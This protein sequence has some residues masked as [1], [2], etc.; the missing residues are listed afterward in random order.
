MVNPFEKKYEN[1]KSWR[2]VAKLRLWS[3]SQCF[4]LFQ[5]KKNVFFDFALVIFIK[6]EKKINGNKTH[7]CRWLSF[8]QRKAFILYKWC[9]RKE[10]DPF[11]LDE[12]V[13][14]MLCFYYF[15]CLIFF[16]TRSDLFFNEKKKLFVFLTGHIMQ[17]T[18]F[19]TKKTPADLQNTAKYCCKR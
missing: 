19:E 2:P 9:C 11:N 15:L 10:G 8:E 12:R 1:K 18:N 13:S 3:H 5:V 7:M 14:M 6:F 4:L 17:C 16:H